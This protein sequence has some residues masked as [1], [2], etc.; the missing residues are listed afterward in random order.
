MGLCHGRRLDAKDP[1]PMSCWNA[2]LRTNA[3]RPKRQVPA[4]KQQKDDPRLMF[5]A[6]LGLISAVDREPQRRALHGVGAAVAG[7]QVME[8]VRH[9]V[10]CRGRPGNLI[11]A[12]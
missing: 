10:L 5:L 8:R 9:T 7:V 2:P 6:S 11:P 3:A 12:P 1:I 4:R